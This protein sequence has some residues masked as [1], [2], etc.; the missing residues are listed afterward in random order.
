MK[1]TK[2]LLKELKIIEDSIYAYENGYYDTHNLDYI[3]DHLYDYKKTIENYTE[4]LPNKEYG[5][6]AYDLKGNNLVLN[7]S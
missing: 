2:E 7:I 3:G 4:H 5:F 6:C 1:W